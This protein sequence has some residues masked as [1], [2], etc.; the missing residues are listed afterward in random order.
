MDMINV[1][2]DDVQILGKKFTFNTN[3]HWNHSKDYIMLFEE[4]MSPYVY[5]LLLYLFIIK[6]IGL[7]TGNNS[8][9]VESLS[10]TESIFDYHLQTGQK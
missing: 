1:L 8:C 3:F 6:L 4:G 2:S 10:R 7:V 9:H 5:T